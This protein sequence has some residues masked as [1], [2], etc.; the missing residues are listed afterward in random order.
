MGALVGVD[1]GVGVGMGVESGTA[2]L[3]GVT[4]AAGVAGGGTEVLVH[5]AEESTRAPASTGVT[6]Q[7]RTF[8]R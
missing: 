2:A 7:E 3:D 4:S 5:E 6:S 1:V 8:T